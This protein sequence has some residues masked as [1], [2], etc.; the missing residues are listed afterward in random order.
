MPHDANPSVPSGW[1]IPILEEET[2]ATQ[3]LGSND[4][5]V[6]DGANVK[7]PNP[8]RAQAWVNRHPFGGRRHHLVGL[9]VRSCADVIDVAAF[10]S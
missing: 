8:Y 6:G 9:T 1:R 4:R 5:S 10:D 3:S 7:G 2:H